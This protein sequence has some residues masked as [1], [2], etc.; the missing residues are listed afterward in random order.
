TLVTV[1]AFYQS[2]SGVTQYADGVRSIYT[3]GVPDF[4]FYLLGTFSPRALWY[5][6]PVAIAL[7]TPDVTLALLALACLLVL[8]PGSRVAHGIWLLIPVALILAVSSQDP[9]NL[10]LRRVIPIYPF[11]F[12]WIGERFGRVWEHYS[13]SANRRAVGW[14]AGVVLLLVVAEGVV[15]AIQI[16][17][18]Q[19][20]YFNRLV[21]G[22]EAGPRYLDDSNIDWG[23]DLPGLAAWQSAIG[24]RPLAL[25]YF[26]TDNPAWYRIT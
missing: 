22:P 16:H 5:Y 13:Q 19:L 3:N 18:Y 12:V 25:W 17:P 7:K 4:K 6:Y 2:F 23:Q 14:I 26:G 1:S 10:G 21:G 11:L 24:A 8:I 15:S 20:A 9:V